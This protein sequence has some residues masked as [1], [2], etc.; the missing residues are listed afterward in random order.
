ML[1]ELIRTELATAQPERMIA[2]GKQIEVARVRI[3]EA[4][5]Q[6]LARVRSRR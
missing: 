1:V 5:R 2:D 4:G 6:A 3:T